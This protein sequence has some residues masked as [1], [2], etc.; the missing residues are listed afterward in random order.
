MPPTAPAPKMISETL[1]P[2]RPKVR[3]FMVLLRLESDLLH[4]LR[5]HR[6]FL[7]HERADF[8]RRRPHGIETLAVEAL[9]RLRQ[10]EDPDEL[11]RELGDDRL[12][13]FRGHDDAV[14]HDL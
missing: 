9:L 2:L 1:M 4:E 6:S 12:G 3:C 13:R 8:L 7:P 10:P 11:V 14:P 5:V